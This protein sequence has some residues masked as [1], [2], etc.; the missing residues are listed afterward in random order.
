MLSSVPSEFLMNDITFK[1]IYVIGSNLMILL[2]KL[3]QKVL[4]MILNPIINVT[5]ILNIIWKTLESH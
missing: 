1:K 2:C 4:E 5:L 3:P